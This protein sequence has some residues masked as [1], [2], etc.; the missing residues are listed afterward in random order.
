MDNA[1]KEL[2]EKGLVFVEHRYQ[3]GH[4]S[5][6]QYHLRDVQRMW[7]ERYFI[8]EALEEKLKREEE[9][10]KMVQELLSENEF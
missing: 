1:L 8:P 10:E 2:Q 4:Q 3:G 6:N 7:M 9:S 5:S